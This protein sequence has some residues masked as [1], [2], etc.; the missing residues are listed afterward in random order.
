MAR[1]KRHTEVISALNGAIFPKEMDLN[2]RARFLFRVSSGQMSSSS[3]GPL[4][5]VGSVTHFPYGEVIL[6]A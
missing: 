6:V 5:L 2:N 3:L 1:I 4:L